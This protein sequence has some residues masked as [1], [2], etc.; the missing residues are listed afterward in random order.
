MKVAK[1]CTHVIFTQ[2]FSVSIYTLN[3]ET[4]YLQGQKRTST[5]GFGALFHNHLFSIIFIFTG[6]FLVDYVLINFAVAWYKYSTFKSTGRFRHS[7]YFLL[8]TGQK[9]QIPK[10]HDPSIIIHLTISLCFI[11]INTN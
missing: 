6:I 4:L 10:G 8:C 11:N 7:S 3:Q 2:L 5:V 9:L 1:V